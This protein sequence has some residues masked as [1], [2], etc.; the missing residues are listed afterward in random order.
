MAIGGNMARPLNVRAVQAPSEVDWWTQLTLRRQGR[1]DARRYRSLNDYTRT[2]ALIVAQNKTNAGQRNVNQWVIQSV[3]PIRTGNARILVQLE[4]L[5]DKLQRLQITSETS[6]RRK[7]EL[8]AL[9]ERLEK[10][11][12]NYT[13]QYQTNLAAAESVLLQGEQAIG[14]WANYYEQ[15]AGI[16]TRARAAKLKIDVSSVEAE[17]PTLE[18]VELVEIPELLVSKADEKEMKK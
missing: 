11:I 4:V 18:S 13:S 17:V 6:G 16:Y 10:Q 5:A 2:H 14:S 12:S 1:Q 15:L 8:S 7:R 3:E 9:Q